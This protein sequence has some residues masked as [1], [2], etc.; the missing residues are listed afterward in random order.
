MDPFFRVFYDAHA[1]FSGPRLSSTLIP[2]APS[3]N[4]NALRQFYADSSVFSISG[5]IWHFL[6]P[7]TSNLSKAE[8]NAWKDVYIAY[9]KAIGEVVRAESGKHRDDWAVRVYETW[10]EVTNTLIRGYSS[11]NFAAWTM[12]CLYVAGKYLR[13][14]AIKADGEQ[15]LKSMAGGGFTETDGLGDDIASTFERNARLEDAARVINRIFTLCISDRAPLEESRKWGL[16]YTTNL[17]F[18]TYFK[19]NS[20]SL[21]K[22]ILRALES[23]KTDM[24][25]QSAFPKSHIVTFNYYV[26]LIHFLDE[27]YSLVTHPILHL[28]PFPNPN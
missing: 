23:S 21:S 17:L 13:V 5:D 4:P 7:V 9:W 2:I 26:G 24:P 14:F 3:A 1:S 6:Q 25:P 8:A 11:G 19:L 20:I 15:R 18:K 27:D 28:T 22:N 16:Y 10:K 12:P